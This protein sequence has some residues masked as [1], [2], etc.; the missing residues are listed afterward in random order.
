[1]FVDSY[2]AGPGPAR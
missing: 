1:M 2:Q